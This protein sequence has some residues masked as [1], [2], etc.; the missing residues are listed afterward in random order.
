MS[1]A[2]FDPDRHLDHMAAV[3]GLAVA[4]Q[5]RAGVVANLAVAAAMADLV[6]SFPL[7]DHEEPATVFEADR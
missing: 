6:A 7:D 3:L 1:G 4:P 5:W 2:A